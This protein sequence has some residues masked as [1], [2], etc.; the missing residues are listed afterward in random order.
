MAFSINI[1]DN[2]KLQ[3]AT[4]FEH[5]EANSLVLTWL[6]GSHKLQTVLGS[7]FGFSMEVTNYQDAYFSHLATHDER[8]YRV[9]IVNEDTTAILWQGHL[10]PDQYEEP[11]TNG[12]FFVNFIA[13]CGLG[14][15]KNQF[16]PND[17]YIEE[18][19]L[20]EVLAA[21][22]KLTGLTLDICMAPALVNKIQ[23]KWLDAIIDTSQYAL[24]S[25]VND[26]YEILKQLMAASLCRIHQVDNAW[27]VV[28]LNQL[29]RFDISF[30]KY[31]AAGVYQ[32]EVIVARTPK[33][34]TFYNIPVITANTPR[35]RISVFHDLNLEQIDKAVYKQENDGYVLATDIELTNHEW[36]YSNVSFVPK[37]NTQNGLTFFAPLTT[38]PT[39]SIRLR[40]EVLIAA[41]SK[42]EWVVKLY[43]EYE[44]STQGRSDDDIFLDGDW[45]KLQPY[46]IYYTDVTTGNEVLLYSNINGTAPDDLRY[47]LG[48]SKDRKAALAIKMIAPET[49]YYNIRFYQPQGVSGVKVDRIILEELQ[50]VILDQEEEQYY[51]DEINETY[52]QDEE[53][54]ISLHDDIRKLENFMRLSRLNDAGVVYDSEVF[55]NFNT[56]NNEDGNYIELSLA[57]L[58]LALANPLY[59][60]VNN[61]PLLIIGFEYNYLGS[62]EMLLQYDADDFGGLVQNGD[63][64]RIEQRAFAPIPNN[65]AEWQLYTD[66]FYG[67]SFA[68]FGDVYAKIVRNLY[69]KSHPI[70]TGTCKGFVSPLDMVSFQYQ[71]QKTLYPLD[72]VWLLDRYESELILSQNFY[73]QAVT[74]NLPPTVD[75]GVDQALAAADFDTTLVAVA[76]D[77]DGTIV[78][79]LWEQLSGDGNVLFGATDQLT[80]TI[81]GLI[82]DAYEFVVT[83][84]DD[85]GLTASD[86]VRVT[87]AVD[88]TLVLTPVVDYENSGADDPQYDFQRIDREWYDITIEPPLES[89]QVV[90]L[91]IDGILVRDTPAFIA[92]ALPTVVFTM[93]YEF[94]YFDAGAYQMV[95]LMRTG[96][97]KR[98]AMQAKVFNTARFGLYPEYAEKVHAKVQADITAEIVSGKAGVFTNVP[99]QKIVEARR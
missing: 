90:R 31:D 97:V 25:G 86:T 93:S 66:A 36:V 92:G 46:D 7:E 27:Y 64:I 79:V 83:V 94:Q 1:Y 11:F 56:L 14:S 17:F 60:T 80:T 71:G 76:N 8:R 52:T 75:A 53:I 65:V 70:I 37:Y 45:V 61:T 2:E 62:Q 35:K 29:N 91:T 58:K 98:L 68:R 39:Q 30:S 59:V 5:A 43:S 55:S 67:V 48:F 10:L 20:I 78:T 24:Q 41:G 28:G 69:T 73:G 74:E 40:K 49:A 9:T 4:V 77:P 85:I 42:M 96:D 3:S 6:G 50:V 23:P 72:V 51:I 81:D 19:S 63:S 38:T 12:A 54:E 21:I 15:L 88:Y 16:L 87:R 22:L 82:G 26:A 95:T 33:T 18:K 84:T 44:G 99:I 13:S 89:D 32:N 47:Q 57:F 34:P